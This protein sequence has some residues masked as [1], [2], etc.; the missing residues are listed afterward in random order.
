MAIPVT[1]NNQNI[2]FVRLVVLDL[3]TRPQPAIALFPQNPDGTSLLVNV[4]TTT[5]NIRYVSTSTST[6]SFNYIGKT[7]EE[8]CNE[9][10]LDTIPITAVSCLREKILSQGDIYLKDTSS[11]FKIPD[12][13][14]ALERTVKNGIY[15]RSKN[16]TVK[17]K[18]DSNFKL[19]APYNNSFL[20]PWNPVITNSSFI[21]HKNGKAFKYSIPEYHNQVWSL[22]YGKP[23]KDVI[24]EKLSLVKKNV[25]KVSRTPIFWNGEN[26]NLYNDDSLV[27]PSLIDDVD[28]NN[29]LV[30]V[31]ENT[32]ISDSTRIDYSYIEN[33]YEYNYLNINCHFSQN[34]S[35]LNKFVLIYAI[36]EEGANYT[37]N[38][39]TIFHSVG[40][41]L[42][43]AINSI[44]HANNDYDYVIIG[45]YSCHQVLPSNSINLLDT[46]VKGGGL[47]ENTGPVSPVHEVSNILD[48]EE[49]TN[50]IEDKYRESKFYFDIGT[51]DG[52]LYP[53]AGAVVVELPST[54]KEKI[55]EGDIRAGVTKFLGAG[56]LP[57]I[58]YYDRVLPSVDGIS[59]QISMVFNGGMSE[60]TYGYSGSCWN[61]F[62]V[63]IGYHPSTGVFS[64]S[65]E[66][67]RNNVVFIDGTGVI[68]TNPNYGTRQSYLKSTPDAGIQY[69]TRTVDIDSYSSH[70]GYR[71]SA[72]K[73]VT[74]FDTREVA[75]GQLKKGYVYFEPS[76]NNKEYSR[77]T[78]NSPF[79]LDSTG[80][81]KNEVSQEIYSIHNKILGLVEDIDFT[82]T[83]SI[84]EEI[85][86]PQVINTYDSVSNTGLSQIGDYFG[87]SKIYNYLF[88]LQDSDLI[89]TYSGT[90]DLVGKSMLQTFS[91][92]SNQDLKY[93]DV[94]S[95]IYTHTNDSISSVEIKD[96][97]S[98]ITKY[99]IFRS[100]LYGTGDYVYQYICDRLLPLNSGHLFLLSNN[101]LP[102]SYDYV[103]NS[104]TETITIEGVSPLVPELSGYSQ[105][106]IVETNNND[107]E[108]LD[109]VQHIGSTAKLVNDFS[110]SFASSMIPLM[111]TYLS[112]IQKTFNRAQNAINYYRT[113]NGNSVVQ[114]WYNPYNRYGKYVGNYSK[115]LINYANCLLYAQTNGTGVTYSNQSGIDVCALE[116]VFSKINSVLTYVSSGFTETVINGGLLDEYTPYLLESYG[117]YVN[118]Y[119]SILSHISGYNPSVSIPNNTNLFSGIFH[120]GLYTTIKGMT[121]TNGDMFE[122]TI[123]DGDPGPFQVH[124]PKYIFDALAEGV[125]MDSNLYL[126]IANSVFNTVKNNYSIDGIYYTDPLK[127]LDYGTYEHEIAP[128]LVKLYKSL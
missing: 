71:F 19:L 126:P 67:I 32:V 20:L 123:V 89:D 83:T 64:V 86:A 60:N 81:F 47:I 108:Y 103:Y 80:N 3:V 87:C 44:S 92:G 42:E 61:R 50:K 111:S 91:D 76:H 51:Y 24:G 95:Q 26:L 27:P 21:A 35:L 8:L 74:E 73:K 55:S 52:Q 53:G 9:I 41:S 2:D 102:A 121:T 122:T 90:I 22:K 62:P 13:F 11:Y 125:I 45:A 18:Q 66:P 97:Y 109:T 82:I 6:S 39:R 4:S 69:Y 117:W 65:D 106:E 128:H 37:I 105:A 75:S 16:Y 116:S 119:Q 38:K 77:V 59:T 68:R 49:T 25:Y 58:S 14:T 114:H 54:V 94:H 29:G 5:I 12:E 127:S 85:T 120:T 88:D 56:I 63:D 57:N 46:R 70:D 96:F 99:G 30:Y 79:R 36:P 43:E 78:V 40:D 17:H 110:G 118:N 93:F 72:W 33:N 28:T 7:V 84:D 113:N 15:I 31:K 112:G 104:T 107:F 124:V 48:L 10:N 1:S 115:Q 98:N 34:P 23:F 100:R 101:Y